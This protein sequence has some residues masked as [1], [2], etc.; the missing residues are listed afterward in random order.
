MPDM[1]LP[2]NSDAER[3][4][5]S[6]ILIEPTLIPECISRKLKSDDFYNVN[7]Q[8]IYN[9]IINLYYKNMSINPV[10][11]GDELKTMKVYELCWW[12]EALYELNAFEFN[13]EPFSDYVSIVISRSR[14][15]QFI[16]EIK[17][18]IPLAYD[19]SSDDAMSK[20]RVATHSLLNSEFNSSEWGLLGKSYDKLVDA[21]KA[22]WLK[23][24]CYTWFDLLD[25]YTKGF[26]E[27][28]VWV[29]W[30]RSRMWKST[31]C[32]N[33]LINACKQWVK[34]CLFTLEVNAQE[35]SEKIMSNICWIDS[36]E[37]NASWMT[38]EVL[39]K[40]EEW[41]AEV[42]PVKE[43]LYIYDKTRRYEDIISQIYALS[44]QWVKIFC[45][46]H[47]LLIKSQEKRQNKVNELWDM[48]NGLKWIAQ[49]LDICI[50]LVSQF[51][52]R[53]DDRYDNEPRISDF[54]WASDI[55]N[56]ANVALGIV[57]VE[58]IDKDWCAEEDKNT[59]DIYI[60]KNRKNPIANFRYK[61]DMAYSKVYDWWTI[62]WSQD[63]KKREE[64]KKKELI[65]KDLKKTE[66]TLYNKSI[67]DIA[68]WV[69]IDSLSDD[70]MPF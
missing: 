55:E 22:G 38:D 18:I 67:E 62:T 31:L 59:M 49:E 70:D 28:A 61:C 10:T 44:W 69:E 24:I 26:W 7:A 9:A 11:V 15:R 35:V 56:I 30:A 36:A 25:E 57:Q 23:P 58:M 33:M 45:I 37:F 51:N 5:L 13:T 6:C 32:I 64:K 43:N 4:L 66:N 21:M 34:C 1:Q 68:S 39:Q 54:N 40:I 20:L 29:V 50:I 8:H 63:S 19:N 42:K 65:K 16:R 48:V 3:G 53:V 17:K 12:L 52:R 60:L 47:L 14:Q 27:T 2:Y 41:E 46:D